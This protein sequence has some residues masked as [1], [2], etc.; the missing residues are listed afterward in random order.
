MNIHS[1]LMSNL[2]LLT[3]LVGIQQPVM[4]A[5]RHKD[6]S[7]SSHHHKK[8]KCCKKILHRVDEINETTQTDLAVDQEILDIVSC[9]NPTRIMQD[10]VGTNGLVISESGKAAL[11][12]SIVFSPL[13]PGKVAIT[14]DADNVV[15]DL[16]GFNLSQGNQ[17]L[18]T[19]G[20]V[21]NT[22][23]T[24]VTIIGSNGSITNFSRNGIYVQGGNREIQLGEVDTR[25]YVTD[26]GGITSDVHSSGLEAGIVVGESK[27]LSANPV[28]R[29]PYKGTI[30]NLRLLNVIAD[31]NSPMGY[32]FGG[33]GSNYAMEDCSGSYNFESRN[34][35]NPL[36]FGPI[37]AFGGASFSNSIAGD[38]GIENFSIEGC[39]FNENEATGTASLDSVCIG[40]GGT[41]L[42]SDVTIR[43]SY[44]NGNQSNNLT[45]G[46]GFGGQSRTL[47]EDCEMCNNKS[48]KQTEGFH[49]SGYSGI[50]P[51]PETLVNSESL[52]VRRCILSGNTVD[53]ALLLN[54]NYSDFAAAQGMSTQWARNV[55][56]IDCTTER[57]IVILD[58]S[59]FATHPNCNAQGV[60]INAGATQV[61]GSYYVDFP[62][63]PYTIINLIS[64]SNYVAGTSPNCRSMGLGFYAEDCTDCHIYGLPDLPNPVRNVLVKGC[65]FANNIFHDPLAVTQTSSGVDTYFNYFTGQFDRSQFTFEDN[66]ITGHHIGI[67][68][69]GFGKTN[70]QRNTFTNHSQAG[71]SIANCGCSSIIY[72][73]FTN[74]T[75]SVIDTE[76]PSSTL[77][78]YNTG[79]NN[80]ATPYSVIYAAPLLT[81]PVVFGNL[82]TNYP[83]SPLVSGANVE[84]NGPCTLIP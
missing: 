65:T 28:Y 14:I 68:H 15:L 66:V 83:P 27:Q 78:A 42:N 30:E 43:K 49:Q 45:W 52:F 44:F 35:S 80:S 71:I 1:F 18:N 37:T 11:C 53:Q 63:S 54:G 2:C 51:T 40:F 20:I 59:V 12:E 73:T 39:S 36:Q 70:F 19:I 58:P 34:S 72:N 16:A 50:A 8:K 64:S 38:V 75:F 32:C 77:V 69:Q 76:N 81:P 9:G 84:W 21:V 33:N 79:F 22:G 74:N 23:H 26:N 60:S 55:K 82:T 56:I 6:S 47:I 10:M 24:N 57:N 41:N 48:G 31:R 46:L 62:G 4:A 29:L 17:V 7:S 3:A 25:L 67:H 61:N 13:V 5:K